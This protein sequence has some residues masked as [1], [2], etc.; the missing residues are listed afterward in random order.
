MD[1][2][3]LAAGLRT[4]ES[5][6]PKALCEALAHLSPQGVW[7]VWCLDTEAGE[8][9]CVAAAT[10][11]AAPAEL[12]PC[13]TWA[14]STVFADAGD[15]PWTEAEAG[16]VLRAAAAKAPGQFAALTEGETLV[17]A[18]QRVAVHDAH[19]WYVI[20]VCDARPHAV[21]VVPLLQLVATALA[22]AP[23]GAA[24]PAPVPTPTAEPED[25]FDFR[26]IA[27]TTPGIMLVLREGRIAYANPATLQGL[28]YTRAELRA[29]DFDP[30]TLIH[31]RDRRRLQPMLAGTVDLPE[32]PLEV[33]M[34]AR[35]G[36]A[37]D[38]L[39]SLTVQHVAGANVVHLR[40]V[41][42]SER[43]QLETDLFAY[44]GHVSALQ[45]LLID[46][47][48]LD[49]TRGQIL[50]RI[51]ESVCTIMGADIVAAFLF[52]ADRSVLALQA[53]HGPRTEDDAWVRGV[54]DSMGERV[55]LPKD[56]WTGEGT[57]ARCLAQQESVVTEHALEQ[58]YVHADLVS[59]MGMDSYLWVPML[60]GK[61]P[62]G[63]L[64]IG[65]RTPTVNMNE[66][67]IQALSLFAAQ[68]ALALQKTALVETERSRQRENTQLLT[69][70][71]ALREDL[72]L[73]QLYERIAM[74]ARQIV[75]CQ[76]CTLTLPVDDTTLMV[77]HADGEAPA[78][79]A[80]IRFPIASTLGGQVMRSGESQRLHEPDA[81]SL[82]HAPK[83]MDVIVRQTLLVPLTSTR[84]TIGVLVLLNK[85][86]DRPF[87]ERD[88]QVIETYAQQAASRLDLATLL[89]EVTETKEYV[90]Y[91][92][93]SANDI[94]YTHDLTGHLTSLNATG[95]RLLGLAPE[96][97]LPN[98]SSVVHPEDL[99]I[100]Q[101]HI[102]AKLE[103]RPEVQPYE[104]RIV[105][106][107]GADIT[108]EIMSRL[109][110]RDG[111]PF[112]VLGIGRDVTERRHL[113]DQV[114]RGEKLAA[115]GGLLAGVA[116]ELNNPLTGVLG[117]AELLVASTDDDVRTQ[118]TRIY[119]EA[120]RCRTIVDALLALHPDS[121]SEAETVGCGPLVEQAVALVR[122]RYES[123]NVQIVV[124]HEADV[125]AV[126]A[127]ADQ[128]QRALLHVL[129]NAQEAIVATGEPGTI[130]V[131]TR[132]H[133]AA[134]HVVIEDT[135]V[136]VAPDVGEQIFDPFY[137]TKD[138]PGRGLGLSMVYNVFSR[139]G[140][141]VT[142][143]P[144]APSG[145]RVILALPAVADTPSLPA[146]PP[147]AE[148]QPAGEARILVVD[149]E[150]VIGDLLVDLLSMMN[151][152]VDVGQ[153]GAAGLALLEQHEYAGIVSDI[154]MPGMNGIDFFRR[155][156]EQFPHMVDR[157]IFSSGDTISP[158][159]HEFLTESGRPYL[160]KPFNL[161]DLRALVSRVIAGADKAA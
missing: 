49:L 132:G 149:D 59:A 123:D 64:Y 46:I 63:V 154:K 126:H 33:C 58:D 141:T 57:L 144:N 48:E 159:T 43:V 102:A 77:K 131:R 67:Q 42:I 83:L 145:T 38:M 109:I 118:A 161:S 24:D 152:T 70:T 122:Y 156:G 69:A 3:A 114:L 107:T 30:L 92:M 54:Q 94:I 105:R 74:G 160:R 16:P 1:W 125:P 2:A 17:A 124:E 113:Q 40:A 120:Q 97:T 62:L 78:N 85:S 9:A 100:A 128:L 139:A 108:L 29:V 104:L 81:D 133:G 136:G 148:P 68:A 116:H 103:G 27:E 135:G 106:D 47:L 66:S 55:H 5:H 36:T 137:T 79:I 71:A 23:V 39:L 98:M 127:S 101:E 153:D 34:E 19:T 28:G 151:Y 25:G 99:P 87:T 60:P 12:G 22:A 56:T 8:V 61:E 45:E 150:E 50:G 129:A 147:E 93:D 138:G 13:G 11:R 35:D 117:Y 110:E 51:C 75:P 158:D 115:L 37:R 18:V 4:N 155:V 121:D 90:E 15:A 82:G 31:P 72:T 119:N 146:P 111:Q 44:T 143:E 157:F 26:D 134:V 84:Q 130:T 95:R 6:T 76:L 96:A 73:E 41:D 21:A 10:G 88:Q 89:S 112:G 53:F 7:S 14:G 52:D 32:G 91:L 65:Y 80:D 140:G 86:G 20:A 142:I